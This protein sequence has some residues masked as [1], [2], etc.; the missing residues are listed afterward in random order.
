MGPA[1]RARVQRQHVAVP[2]RRYAVD[3]PSVGHGAFR[4]VVRRRRDGCRVALIHGEG[5]GGIERNGEGAGRDAEIEESDVAIVLRRVSETDEAG[6]RR[7]VVGEGSPGVGQSG[8]ARGVVGNHGRPGAGLSRR[9]LFHIKDVIPAQ[10]VPLE[11]VGESARLSG[12]LNL[13]PAACVAEL[14]TT[15]GGAVVVVAAAELGLRHP[16][17]VRHAIPRPGV[18]KRQRRVVD[19]SG[20]R[21]GNHRAA[22]RHVEGGAFDGIPVDRDGLEF[23]A[24][25]GIGSDRHRGAGLCPGGFDRNR[26]VGDG[27]I[28]RGVI[29]GHD[30]IGHAVRRR[31]GGRV[32]GRA[33]DRVGT[34]GRAR[35]QHQP[36]AVPARRLAVD[37]P[38]VGYGT[39]GI[40]WRR[41]DGFLSSHFHLEVRC[42][43]EGNREIARR[44]RLG[45]CNRK[46]FAVQR[47]RR[48]RNR[49]DH[50]IGVHR[51]W[52]HCRGNV[53]EIRGIRTMPTC[54]VEL[55]IG[56][57]RNRHFAVRHA[58]GAS[59][60][61]TIGT[62]AQGQIGN[63][64]PVVVC[65]RQR[66]A[67]PGRQLIQVVVAGLQECRTRAVRSRPAHRH[68][69]LCLHRIG[70]RIR[71]HHHHGCRQN[72]ERTGDV[73]H[74]IVP[75]GGVARRRDCVE[76]GGFACLAGKGVAHRVAAE[77][78]GDRRGQRRVGFAGGLR[79]V[80]G[81]DGDRLRG[82][83]E[84]AA[85]RR[86]L[87]VR[88]AARRH[89]DGVIADSLAGFAR[90]RI[91][92]GIARDSARDGRRQCRVAARIVVVNLCL[93]LR[94]HRHCLR[95]HLQR[96]RGA[97]R[98]R[99]VGLRRLGDGR[100]RAHVR[101]GRGRGA[102]G[103]AVVR[104][105][106]NRGIRRIDRRDRRRVRV[107]I[108]GAGIPRRRDGDGRRQNRERARH[109]RDGVIAL[110]G[111]ARRGDGVRAD[112]F[113][114]GAGNRVG[115]R[116][117][118]ERPIDRRGQFRVG[119]A[120][121]LAL[122]V[123]RDGDR[124][125]G[126]GQVRRS[127]VDAVIATGGERPLPDFIGADG[128]ARGARKRTGK[129]VAS[130]EPGRNV[131]QRRVGVAVGLAL[132]LGRDGDRPRSDCQGAG[133]ERDGVVAA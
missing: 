7:Q 32:S 36:V 78:P 91:I 8:A 24:G 102:P 41:R 73:A 88:V 47:V 108:V 97:R 81:R 15:V 44:A 43:V 90:E 25:V 4:R 31:V 71:R 101:D 18:R 68:I 57:A 80:V 74:R 27:R 9:R 75:L 11:V 6:T 69:G 95:R 56:N 33:D 67:V 48:R 133:D 129:R 114:F 125:G 122:V 40:L 94:G 49:D 115:D 5:L 10:S 85:I 29:E 1:G 76:A 46:G 50:V 22:D 84:G 28:N 103:R 112:R 19:D 124:L 120:I 54:L 109:V 38:S 55:R 70:D 37:G 17:H 77:R 72:R 117:C 118:A 65:Q 127:E 26:T 99:V 61:A 79:L 113:A 96:H 100:D 107:A 86:H 93:V 126:N 116:V 51:P 123:R 14:G 53:N 63:R 59:P 130:E 104:A 60:L 58:Q 35:G 128:F 20:E 16:R 87:V 12:E 89:R 2:A 131:G 39:H 132:R 106:L 98:V 3:G 21:R 82:D 23:V 121:G 13:Q 42:R 66:H 62:H 45:V 64:L 105:P 92:N 111:V 119:S 52:R 83:G 30:R 110:R 34:A